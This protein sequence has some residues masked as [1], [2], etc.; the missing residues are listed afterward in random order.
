MDIR[1]GLDGLKSILGVTQPA[2]PAAG[3]VRRGA[4]AESGGLDADQ[5][6]FSQAGSEAAQAAS[7]GD[8]R[9]DKVAQVRAAIAAGTYAVPASAV[10]SRMVDSMLGGR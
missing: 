8:V 5:V 2:A 3:N 4:A 10:A 9:A 6:T 1:S 7:A